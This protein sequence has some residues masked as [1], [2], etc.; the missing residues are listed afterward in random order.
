MLY[1]SVYTVL[2][3]L[4]PFCENFEVIYMLK[5]SQHLGFFEKLQNNNSIDFL[6]FS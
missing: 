2:S 3:K 6:L 4:F 1:M 5:L